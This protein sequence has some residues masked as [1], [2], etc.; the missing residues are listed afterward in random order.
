MGLRNTRIIA[1]FHWNKSICFVLCPF[2]RFYAQDKII[3]I[4]VRTEC[5]IWLEGLVSLNTRQTEELCGTK[6]GGG[7]EKYLFF[8]HCGGISC[9]TWH[10][11]KSRSHVLWSCT[12]FPKQ[13][14]LHTAA[15]CACYFDFLPFLWVPWGATTQWQGW[16]FGQLLLLQKHWAAS[17]RDATYLLPLWISYNGG[18]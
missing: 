12:L 17:V 18:M 4:A 2:G 10:A 7:K 3:P 13:C 6:E 5:L 8:T 14:L 9:M 1:V 16:Q 15:Y 11:V